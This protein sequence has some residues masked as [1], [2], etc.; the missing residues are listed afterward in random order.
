MQTKAINDLLAEVR[1]PGFV[2]SSE[3]IHED[4]KQFEEFRMAITTDVEDVIN[5]RS[6]YLLAIAL[7]EDAAYLAVVK[8]KLGLSGGGAAVASYGICEAAHNMWSKLNQLFSI[9]RDVVLVPN[10]EFKQMIALVYHNSFDPEGVAG[11]IR[12]YLNLSNPTFETTG[13]LL[14]TEDA[15]KLSTCIFENSNDNISDVQFQF[16]ED[17]LIFQDMRASGYGELIYEGVGRSRYIT[18]SG[19]TLDILNFNR[20]EGENAL[21]VDLIYYLRE[22]RSVV[23]LQYKR[24]N[25]GT[26]YTSS[27]GNYSKEMDRMVNTRSIFEIPDL[28]NDFA[29]KLFRLSECPYYLKLCPDSSLTTNKFVSGACIHLDHWNRLMLSPKCTTSHGNHK[30]SYDD[31]DGRHLRSGEF[32]HLVKRGLIGGYLASIEHL[33]QII[34]QLHAQ[35]HMV[36]SAIETPGRGY[37][38]G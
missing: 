4:I 18:R 29:H 20:K 32:I 25:G 6:P 5:R 38:D 16:N 26:Y 35:K 13:N 37:V 3:A 36:V 7:T 21:G 28:G 33:M 12:K 31:L 14:F 27:D 2:L 8:R 30:L 34:K 24:I 17:D 19:R 9:K 10:D 11:I 23:M 1:T 22:Y 15:E